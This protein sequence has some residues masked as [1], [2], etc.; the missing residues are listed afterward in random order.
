MSKLDQ[1]KALG[2]AKRSARNSSDGGAY[3]RAPMAHSGPAGVRPEKA[4]LMVEAG[5]ATCS[6]ETKLKRGRPRLT[7][8]RPW[9]TQGISK[10]TYYRRQAKAAKGEME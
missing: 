6:S 10:R 9:E 1:I 7:E 2:D 8:P 4:N 5:V 3:L